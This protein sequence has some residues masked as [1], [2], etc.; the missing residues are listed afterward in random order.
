MQTAIIR[1][2]AATLAVAS[3]HI[4]TLPHR[5]AS[6]NHLQDEWGNAQSLVPHCCSLRRCGRTAISA[7]SSVQTRKKRRDHNDN[8]LLASLPAADCRRL[9]K[10]AERIELI[11]ADTLASAGERILY[12]YFPL[13][14]LISLITPIDRRAQLE[15]ALIGNEGMLGVSLALGVN[16]APLRALV[17]GAGLAWRVDAATFVRELERS[18]MLRHSVN[19][20]LHVLVCQLAQT[21]ACTRFHFVDARLARWLLMARDRS[22]SSKLH[23]THEFLARVLGV[24]RVGV[25]RAAS[26]M[27]RSELIRYSRGHL[28]ILD[29]RRLEAVACECY[30]NGKAAYASMLR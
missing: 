22:R 19:R 17:Q 14:A 30:A 2:H 1:I 5:C 6:S 9:C 26:E 16:I 21:S 29:V 15:V 12:V 3:D 11:G 27:R 4:R 28:E 23:V 18:E 20:Y 8:L 24:R 13:D 7:Q 25:T 10:E